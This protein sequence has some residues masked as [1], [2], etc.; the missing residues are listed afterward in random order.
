MTPESKA[1]VELIKSCGFRVFMRNP[2]YN[3]CF[4]TDGTRVAY[5]QWGIKEYVGTVHKANTT[6]GTGYLFEETI[7]STSL[8]GALACHAPNWDA[9]KASTVQKYKNWAEYHNASAFNRELFEV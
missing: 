6:T 8:E 9:H 2:N 7:T 5:A 4:Y 3:Y 1:K